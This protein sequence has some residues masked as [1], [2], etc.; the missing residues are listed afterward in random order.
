MMPFSQ[1]RSLDSV[2]NKGGGCSKIW[3]TNNLRYTCSR[4]LIYSEQITCTKHTAAALTNNNNNNTA[5]LFL[6]ISFFSFKNFPICLPFN[7]FTLSSARQRAWILHSMSRLSR[8]LNLIVVA[9]FIWN[10]MIDR[11]FPF[12][13]N[14]ASNISLLEST[15][16]SPSIFDEEN[17]DYL[18][19]ISPDSS[20]DDWDTSSPKS[21][22]V[23]SDD[24]IF[25]SDPFEISSCATSN[26]DDI[27]VVEKR[28]R[29]PKRDICL[30]TSQEE[31][32]PDSSPVLE[33]PNLFGLERPPQQEQQGSLPDPLKLY[34][35]YE[36]CPASRPN[37]ICCWGPSAVADE[38]LPFFKGVRSC[39]RMGFWHC[40]SHPRSE[41]QDRVM[42]GFYL[43]ADM[44]Q[45]VWSFLDV[46]CPEF[47]TA[48]CCRL[49]FV[50]GHSLIHSSI[51]SESIPPRPQK[52]VAKHG[53]FA[54]AT[55][56]I[57]AGSRY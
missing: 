50:R 8:R 35:P 25:G 21:S 39:V 49:F 27:Q 23:F 46:Q 1:P 33:L 34:D 11:V 18:D 13:L 30:P 19:L 22:L 20:F 3:S 42:S 54:N 5:I 48:Y 4:Y 38:G 6:V 53:F 44:T 14:D 26:D 15:T 24:D 52:Q 45:H 51:S 37:G 32:K 16:N 28:T 47:T 40:T 29:K 55:G 31:N 2:S 41:V 10:T 12:E 57:L 9:F 17:G 56:F 7:C 43:I 36:E